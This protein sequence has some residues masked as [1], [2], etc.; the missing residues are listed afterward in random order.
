MSPG[1]RCWGSR[2]RYLTMRPLTSWKGAARLFERDA[3]ESKAQ[4]EKSDRN[5][6]KEL[7]NDSERFDFKIYF[8]EVFRQKGGFDVVIGNPALLAYT[9]IKESFGEQVEVF[10]REFKSATG[11]YDLYVLFIELALLISAEK[12]YSSFIVP[13]KFTNSSYGKGIREL[14]IGSKAAHSLLSFGSSVVFE[15][16]ATYT[17][18]LG[19]KKH[20]EVL[21]FTHVKP[22]QLVSRNFKLTKVPHST[23]SPSPWVLTTDERKKNY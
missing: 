10:K 8:S 11:K 22:N 15:D 5:A 12:G 9:G 14:L 19:L 1:T 2:R 17:C 4:P 23:L 7:T 3:L 13:Q 16:V 20:S 6:D 21:K 18:I